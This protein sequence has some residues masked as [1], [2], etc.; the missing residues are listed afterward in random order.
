MKVTT[1]RPDKIKSILWRVTENKRAAFYPYGERVFKRA[2]NAQ[3]A[4]FIRELLRSGVMQES[5]VST[6]PMEIAFV[7]VYG[8][9]GTS[10][11]ADT[12]GAVTKSYHPK[13]EVKRRRR[14]RFVNTEQAQV[15]DSTWLQYMRRYALTESGNRITKITETTKEIIRN[16]LTKSIN[17]GHGIDEAARNLMKEWRGISTTRA[18]VIA[19]TEIL[20]ASNAGSYAGAQSTGLDLQKVWLST[21]DSRTRDTHRHLD[22]EKVEMEELFSNG[23]RYPGDPRGSASQVIQCRCTQTY[24]V[25]E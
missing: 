18:K 23:L 3:F 10:F 7:Q 12:Y 19:R 20:S 8:R 4:P 22:G 1:S 9:V 14:R 11:A 21:K 13:Y 2:L 17:E 5:L 6:L 16:S 25:K 15:L 24:E